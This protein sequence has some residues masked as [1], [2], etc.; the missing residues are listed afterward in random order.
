MAL[1]K[2]PERRLKA[3]V[4]YRLTEPA[5]ITSSIPDTSIV[6]S[7]AIF[8]LEI[9]STTPPSTMIFPNIKVLSPCST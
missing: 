2:L 7:N 9:I 6:P 1:I 4:A 5:L 8:L 3:L